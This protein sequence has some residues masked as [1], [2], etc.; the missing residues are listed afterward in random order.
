MK[1]KCVPMSIPVTQRQPTQ[2]RTTNATGINKQLTGSKYLSGNNL[3]LISLIGGK[4]FPDRYLYT[5]F[6]P[7][8]FNCV[9]CCQSRWLSQGNWCDEEELGNP[10]KRIGSGKRIPANFLER[11]NYNHQAEKVESV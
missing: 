8:D 5:M 9:C 3:P 11:K 2:Q 1:K 4:L 10:G 7:I 6:P